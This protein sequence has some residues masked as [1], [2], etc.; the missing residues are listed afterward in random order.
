MNKFQKIH[1]LSQALDMWKPLY[2]SHSVTRDAEEGWSFRRNIVRSCVVVNFGRVKSRTE[3][4]PSMMPALG[5]TFPMISIGS[6][7]PIRIGLVK[8]LTPW[9]MI[10]DLADLLLFNLTSPCCCKSFSYTM[11]LHRFC[12]C[13]YLWWFPRY[14]DCSIEST[15]VTQYAAQYKQLCYIK[16][17]RAILWKG[18]VKE[19]HHF[20]IRVLL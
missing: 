3:C 11:T 16:P 9:P 18:F 6:L 12:T 7:H 20:P 8:K 15:S 1:D 2:T 19:G 14:K 4:K 13:C 17:P 5:S 10:S